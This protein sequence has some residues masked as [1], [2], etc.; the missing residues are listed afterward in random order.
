[1]QTI[2]LFPIGNTLFPDGVLALQVFEV[3]YLDMIRKCIADNTEFGVVAL[4][5]G[6]EVRTPEGGEVLAEIGTLARIE[7]SHSPLPALMR[8]RCIGTR[9]F[10]LR[11]TE[12]RKYGLWVGEADLLPQDPVAAIPAKMQDAAN[13][14]GRL[15][16]GWQQDGIPADAMPVAAPYRLDEAG[17]VANRWGDLLPLTIPDKIALLAEDDPVARLRDA[18][19]VLG[20]RG[21][22]PD[23]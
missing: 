21:L 11:H 12:Q 5:S 16:A 4:L 14:L 6:S 7:Q 18:R 15:I 19:E 22:L 23:E 8:L 10:R 9:R 2:P 20:N 13:A 17:W 1:M 3:R